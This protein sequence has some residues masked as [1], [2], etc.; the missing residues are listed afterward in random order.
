MT[1]RLTPDRRSA[2]MAKVRSQHTGPERAVR[3]IS[4]RLGYRF[5]LHKK[6]L[7][8][9][10]DLV[11]PR[12][13]S[14]IL[15]H[16]CFWHR[17]S[18]CRKASMPKTRIEFWKAKFERNVSRDIA[19]RLALKKQGWR[20]L[21]VWECQL[22]KPTLVEKRVQKFLSACDQRKTVKSVR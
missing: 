20:V 21:T 11:F 12:L 17:H 9:T 14:V 5:R 18:N 8:G 15:V 13:R 19:V 10:P 22:K 6:E 16:G 3:A 4:H 1:D 2:L 7:P